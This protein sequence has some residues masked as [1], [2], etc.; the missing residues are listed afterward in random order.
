MPKTLRQSNIELLRVLCMLMVIGLHANF[1]ALGYPRPRVVLADPLGWLGRIGTEMICISSVDCFVL[2][3]G[4]F[5]THF[6]PRRAGALLFQTVFVSAVL[7]AALWLTLGRAPA[8]WRAM[9]AAC[10]HYWFVY[11]Y[12]VLYLFTPMLNSWIERV[13][14]RELRRFVLLF[15][16]VAVPLSFFV[17]D[18]S[19]GFSAVWFMGLYLL[20]RYLRL[21]QAPRWKQI[22]TWRFVAVWGGLVIAMTAA[23]WGHIYFR[24]PWLPYLPTFMTAYTNPLTVACAVCLLLFC[25]RLSFTSRL[26]NW[27]AAGSLTVYLAHQQ[28]FV[29]PFFFEWFRQLG[30][31]FRGPVFVLCAVASACLVYVLSALLDVVRRRVWRLIEHALDVRHPE[32]RS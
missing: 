23:Y 12:L 28:L 5:G 14:E 20:G 27:L 8:G 25:S 6:K 15:I 29:R 1:E 18:L 22:S 2:I 30:H 10:T 24:N 19:R 32:K 11:S 31:E 4:W 7:T 21:Y 26:V 9:V 13:G 16:V 17:N 3:T